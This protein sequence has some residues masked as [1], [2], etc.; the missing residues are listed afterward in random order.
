MEAA[1]FGI[2]IFSYT[3]INEIFTLKTSLYLMPSERSC[4]IDSKLDFDF[5][6]FMITKNK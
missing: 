2:L 3:K 1:I 4:D 6:N 5:V